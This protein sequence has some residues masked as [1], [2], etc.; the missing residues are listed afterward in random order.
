MMRKSLLWLILLLALLVCTP[1]FAEI[2]VFDDLY[3]SMEVPDD[4][5]VL[6]E[7]NM[8]NYADWLEAHGTTLE[9]A[10]ND[11]VRRGVLLQAWNDAGDAC[12]ELRANQDE[13][14]RL[15]FDVNEQTS[16]VRGQ[17]RTSHYPNNEYD[18]YEFSTS[19]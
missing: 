8:V 6:T 14:S 15:L 9:D 19:E 1:A 12:F 5:V 13:R 4:Y 7:K 3:A 11:F 18:G 10:M 16:T 17:Y 2:Y